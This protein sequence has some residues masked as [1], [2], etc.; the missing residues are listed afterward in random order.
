MANLLWGSTSEVRNALPRPPPGIVRES[1]GEEF[2]GF[3]A[4]GGFGEV[5]RVTAASSQCGV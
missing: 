1:E 3:I 4:A 2:D 5:Y